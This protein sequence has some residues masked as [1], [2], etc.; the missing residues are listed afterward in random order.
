MKIVPIV[1]LALAFVSG[2][3]WAE[4]GDVKGGADYPG[5]GRFAG[6]VISGY[7]AKNFDDVV[8]Q[9]KAFA[10]RKPVDARALEGKVTRIAYRASGG[11]SILEVF[12][13][14][15]N[16]AVASGYEVLLECETEQCGAMPFSSAIETLP[17]PRMWFDAFNYRY[18]SAHKQ[19][20]ASNPETYVS[21]ATSKNN[22]DIYTQVTVVELGAIEDKMIDAAAMAKGLAEAGHIALYGIYFDTDKAV[23]K[24]ESAPTLAEIAKLL[25][26]DAALETVYI[27]G[28]TDNQ[29]AYD[30]NLNLSRRRAASIAAE[31]VAKHAIA[32]TRLKTAGVGFLAPMASNANEAGRALNRRTELVVP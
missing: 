29:G 6:S 20:G 12:R 32:A 17:I 19:A 8:I 23:L 4:P 1:A 15:K 28:H 16:K 5:L 3:A 18:L 31:L 21:V 13:N 9:A 11:A 26:A 24:A 7:E 22:D 25:K 27:V 30:Y 2:A 10:N 14:Y